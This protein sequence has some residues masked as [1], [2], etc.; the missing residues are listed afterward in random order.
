M[1]MQLDFII[2]HICV[3]IG[4]LW[5][6]KLGI[7]GIA[8][9]HLEINIRIYEHIYLNTTGFL[10]SLAYVVFGLA[11]TIMTVLSFFQTDYRLLQLV[12]VIWV[13]LIMINIV[14]NWFTPDA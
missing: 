5:I 2:V 13:L 9:R 10:L 6:A 4:S 12:G 7:E 3:L 8:R 1:L 14:V 11:A